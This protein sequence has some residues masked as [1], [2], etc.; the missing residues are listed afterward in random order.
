MKKTRKLPDNKKQKLED[1]MQRISN[2]FNLS[3]M[4]QDIYTGEIK[5]KKPKKLLTTKSK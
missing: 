3:V 4:S 5:I 1:I 2:Y